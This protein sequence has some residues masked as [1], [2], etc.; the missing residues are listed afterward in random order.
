MTDIVKALRRPGASWRELEAVDEIERLRD[1]IK[2]CAA[3]IEVAHLTVG[4]PPSIDYE[5]V[6]KEVSR[7][8]CVA[9]EALDTSVCEGKDD[10]QG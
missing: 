9:S 4:A 6:M 2:E 5:Q 8:I 7:R 1:V 10:A 3:P